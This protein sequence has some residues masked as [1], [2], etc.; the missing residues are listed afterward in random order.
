MKVFKVETIGDCYVAACGLP[1]SRDDHA[2]IMA[3]FSC[4]CLAIFQR[5]IKKLEVELGPGT[6]DLRIR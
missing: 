4:A 2:V 3:R 6:Q 5:K 1:E